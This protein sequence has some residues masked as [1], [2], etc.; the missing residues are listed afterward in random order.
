[1][2]ALD[3]NQDLAAPRSL[4]FGSRKSKLAR[5]QTD[6]V[7]S[8]LTQRFPQTECQVRTFDTVG[9]QTLDQPLPA[10][11]GKGLFTAE[12]DNAIRHQE[13][14]VAIHSLKDLPTTPEKGIV[15]LPLLQ[16]EDPRDVL[17]SSTESSLSELPAGA[18]VGTSSPRRQTQL[19]HLHPHLSVKSIRGNV[20]TRIDKVHTD[21]YDA[22]ILAAAGV[23]RI[24][25][26][27]RV[28]HW[29]PVEQMLPAPGQG[30][31]A[32]TCRKDD[33]TTLRLLRALQDMSTVAPVTAERLLLANL[34][35]GCSAPIAAFGQV[36]SNGDLELIGRVGSLDG[37]TVL[38]ATATDICPTTVAQQVANDLFAQGAAEL[39]PRAGGV[40]CL[41]TSDRIL[42]PL[43]GKKV[44]VTRP[45]GQAA[46]MCE[47]IRAHQAIPLSAPLIETQRLI[48]PGT[49]NLPLDS[50]DDFDWLVF[51]SSNAIRFF[52]ELLGNRQIDT[53]TRV[54]CVGEKTAQVLRHIFREPDFVPQ[55]FSSEAL[56]EQMPL[57]GGTRV[58]IPG[59]LVSQDAFVE[60]MQTRGFQVTRWP[61][62][63]TCFVTLSE[64]IRNELESGV[65]IVTFASP[66]AVD[67]FC[68]QVPDYSALLAHSVVGCIG[69]MTN[70]R[71]QER[72][73]HVHVV[74]PRYTVPDLIQALCDYCN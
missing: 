29:I 24:G 54:A 7:I 35:G 46:P 55:P 62:Y 19:L 59:P 72:N 1:M 6:H 73:I 27:D 49:A 42:S 47:L 9:D 17:I 18:V 39:L 38:T 32:A 13:I 70:R 71:A 37:K 36:L 30:V 58:L 3:S 21:A 34:G 40:V 52:F 8:C 51:A 65:D 68:E 26:Q 56:G 64:S 16:R 28:T 48:E 15:I 69:P 41:M 60:R 5:W 74:P 57:D 50:L 53:A 20:P 4:T 44:L 31:L 67:S 2:A 23:R 45:T 22:V 12:L 43:H 66:S 14:D 63:K 33:E 25:Y 10:I 61:I 11:G